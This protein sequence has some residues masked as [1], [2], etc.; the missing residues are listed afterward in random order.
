MSKYDRNIWGT[1]C[2]NEIVIINAKG[3]V[4][5]FDT[6][7]IIDKDH[8]IMA[9][10]LSQDENL[11]AL[12]T[13][14]IRNYNFDSPVSKLFVMNKKTGEVT[15]YEG[16][17]KSVVGYYPVYPLYFSPDNKKLHAYVAA[18]AGFLSE[19][20][21]SYDLQSKQRQE[22]K[23][24]NIENAGPLVGTIG[25]V[26]SQGYIYVWQEGQP[27]DSLIKY[28]INTG[29]I[30]TEF[31]LGTKIIAESVADFATPFEGIDPK[32]NHAYFNAFT[33]SCRGEDKP[34]NNSNCDQ[35]K[36]GML[37]YDL[38]TKK[39]KYDLRGIMPKNF[40]SIVGHDANYLYVA[41]AHSFNTNNNSAIVDL[42]KVNLISKQLSTIKTTNGEY[43][44]YILIN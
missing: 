10:Q 39:M 11:L 37:V 24:F 26:D 42:Q 40:F 36:V 34:D 43:E 22:I 21:L 3:Q 18:S 15:S 27:N 9:Y 13:S 16:N 20:I 14:P 29:K 8:E 25:N 19:Q 4:S 44:E 35:T 38:N 6:R 17:A 28:D 31:D 32:T 2:N 30:L 12:T 41:D 7:K 33:I 23:A 1:I 5:K